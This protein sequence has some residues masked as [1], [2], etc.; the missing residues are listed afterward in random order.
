ML[1]KIVYPVKL[2]S[3][4]FIFFA[5]ILSANQ[6]MLT[7]TFDDGYA[8]HHETVLPLLE[9]YAFYGT[10]YVSSGLLGES[11]YLTKE[12]MIELSQRGHE[13]GSHCVTHRYLTK[14]PHFEIEQELLESKQTLGK[15]SAD[16]DRSFCSAIWE[17]QSR[18]IARSI[19]NTYQTSRTIARGYNTKNTNRYHIHA[20]SVLNRTSLTEVEKWIDKAI[21]E[22]K[23]VVLVYHHIDATEGIVSITPEEFEN[24]LKMIQ[25]KPIS[26]KTLGEALSSL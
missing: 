16:S 17:N 2:T 5:S 6:G 22:N 13:I 7:L 4:L 11:G 19:K 8:S 1:K 26:V 12:Q 25:S 10:F 14:L 20:F 18:M 15:S 24:H 9:K 21:E 3:L 23:W